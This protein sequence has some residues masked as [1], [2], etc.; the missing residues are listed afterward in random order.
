MDEDGTTPVFREQDFSFEVGAHTVLSAKDLCSISFIDKLV[1]AGIASFKIEGRARNAPYV[2]YVTGAYRRAVD[3][4]MAG[5]FSDALA[6]ELIGET[7]KVFHRQW[8][9]P[10]R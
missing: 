10:F 8:P 1:A 4:V 7:E 3:A 6:A 2:K 9:L 5:N